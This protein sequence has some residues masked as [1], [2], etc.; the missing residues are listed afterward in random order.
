MKKQSNPVVAALAATVAAGIANVIVPAAGQSTD[1]STGDNHISTTVEL[2]RNL[3]AHNCSHCHGPGMINAG[4]VI[5]D[6]RAFPDDQSR[7]VTTV[8]EGKNNRMPPWSQILN[9][10]QIA[11]LWAYV[12]SRRSK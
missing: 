10:D 3:Y 11:D 12:S 9:D 6:L 7:F 8:K 5:P 4:T 1:R 2:G